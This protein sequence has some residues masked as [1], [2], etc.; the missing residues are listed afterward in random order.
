[1]RTDRRIKKGGTTPKKN[2][3]WGEGW[4]KGKAPLFKILKIKKKRPIGGVKEK[5]PSPEDSD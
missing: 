5:K 1:V 3:E 2:E 4:G